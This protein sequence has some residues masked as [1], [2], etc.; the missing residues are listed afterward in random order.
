MEHET[1]REWLDLAADGALPAGDR[2][3]LERHLEGC[4]DCRAE[5]ARLEALAGRLAASR[6]AVRPGFTGEVMAALGPAPWEART[7]RAWRWPFALLLALGGAAA[8]IYGTAAAELDPAGRSW[9]ALAALADLFRA[10]LVAGA[11][12]AAATWSGVGAAVG[13]WLGASPAN[14]LAA[15]VLVVGLNLLAL[16]LVRRR[17]GAAAARPGRRP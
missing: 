11:G 10:A 16:R 8:A 7:P 12:L 14:W 1:W 5:A 6:I 15:G 2:A 9:T 4:A 3:A 17:A 13:E